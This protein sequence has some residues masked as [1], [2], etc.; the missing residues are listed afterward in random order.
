MATIL[1]RTERARRP[2]GPLYQH[3]HHC[4]SSL[5]T[6]L[7]MASTRRLPHHS[8]SSADWPSLAIPLPTFA[9][10]SGQRCASTIS[11]PTRDPIITGP[12][13]IDPSDTSDKQ[14]LESLGA[15]QD[16]FRHECHSMFMDLL[17]SS[18]DAKESGELGDD[19]N[20]L[21][22]LPPNIQ[23]FIQ[24]LRIGDVRTALV[25]IQNDG[26]FLDPAPW[27][28][29]SQPTFSA[30][31]RYLD[32]FKIGPQVDP[33]HDMEIPMA[34]I[35][36]VAFT[37]L[38]EPTGARRIYVFLFRLVNWFFGLRI[39]AGL[40]PARSDW[41]CLM[42]LAGTTGDRKIARRVWSASV[43]IQR[44]P[45]IDVRNTDTFA[46]FIQSRLQT[47]PLY[48]NF[49]I[50]KTRASVFEIGFKSNI[51]ISRGQRKLIY[52]NRLR[53]ALRD[54]QKYPVQTVEQALGSGDIGYGTQWFNDFF[55]FLYKRGIVATED[56]ICTTIV[57]LSR[58]GSL[59]LVRKLLDMAWG[60]Q[61]QVD[62]EASNVTIVGGR[63]IPPGHPLY[64]TKQLLDTVIQA[65]G[66]NSQ[67]QT[68]VKLADFVSSRYDI[69]LTPD[70]WT[71]L[72]TW[73]QVSSSRSVLRE[74][75]QAGFHTKLVD[76][77][78]MYMVWETMTGKP[79]NIK[80]RF[81][82]YEIFIPFLLSSGEINRAAKAIYAAW[83]AHWKTQESEFR[84]A[85]EAYYLSLG[86]E[87][88]TDRQA[89]RYERALVRCKAMRWR[90][91]SWIKKLCSCAAPQSDDDDFIVR[92]LPNMV[93]DF[94]KFD[95]L[96]LTYKTFNGEVSLCMKARDIYSPMVAK[97]L[98][99]SG[100]PAALSWPPP[101]NFT[102]KRWFRHLLAY[103]AR[104][105]GLRYPGDANGPPRGRLGG[106]IIR[107]SRRYTR[108][109]AMQQPSGVERLKSFDGVD[110]WRTVELHYS[111][112]NPIRED[113]T[114]AMFRV[115]RYNLRMLPSAFDATLR[116]QFRRDALLAPTRPRDAFLRGPE[117]KS[118]NSVLKQLTRR[119]RENL[120]ERD[121]WKWK[122]IGHGFLPALH[123][124]ISDK[125][126]WE[127]SA[128]PWPDLNT[129]RRRRLAKARRVRLFLD[130]QAVTEEELQ[131]LELSDSPRLQRVEEPSSKTGNE[132]FFRALWDVQQEDARARTGDPVV[133]VGKDR[134]G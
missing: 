20:H 85:E 15:L 89:I 80:P 107:R 103:R 112:P 130:G 70:A 62:K 93:K 114:S 74:W 40:L 84:K 78:T 98:E 116:K 60:I 6:A 115:P 48:N 65:F 45:G 132:D 19:P 11:A 104:Y 30:I 117:L 83:D 96:P 51:T 36:D 25:Q 87:G 57:A 18:Q 90:I 109:I 42:R 49:S 105:L 63:D 129:A 73:T 75:K 47:I 53:K 120:P 134:L 31:L 77:E 123:P 56:L 128:Q 100:I 110:G 54:L 94:E 22:Q 58:M 124:G 106:S 86:S 44:G 91:S 10:A 97:N 9:S 113:A 33:A 39:G 24:H 66:S 34:A 41:N 7:L 38:I 88:A 32:P 111:R 72:L 125:E 127:Y 5:Q 27:I 16:V 71:A 133:E 2:L 126:P 92:R 23:K 99:L 76:P 55:N 52:H 21:T 95:Q 14:L 35:Q 4:S 12:T 3:F 118:L 81:C 122:E 13:G 8:P 121:L 17:P 37:D 59:N 79:Y 28:K 119:A 131:R 29:M 68:C 69:P 1:S 102:S 108:S 67:I 26:G 64:P 101:S 46:D 61:I 43:S 50:P 82:D